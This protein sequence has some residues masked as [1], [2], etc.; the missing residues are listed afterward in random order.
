LAIERQGIDEPAV[1]EDAA[2]DL[3][4]MEDH[5]QRHAGGHRPAQRSRR[6]DDRFLRVEIRRHDLQRYGEVREVARHAR[7]HDRI[8][9][10]LGRNECRPRRQGAEHTARH[11]NARRVEV[12][13]QVETLL[14]HLEGVHAELL[15]AESRGVGGSKHG[16][17]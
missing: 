8:E 3:D 11:A 6:E 15:A 12:A 5:R 9:E 14:Q 4:R 16:A 10:S 13:D 2:V 1:D 17:D 7:R